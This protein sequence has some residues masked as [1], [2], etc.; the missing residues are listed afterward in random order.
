MMKDIVSKYLLILFGVIACTVSSCGC[1]GSS[2]DAE[3]PVN[4]PLV[5]DSDVAILVTSNDRTL[6]LA[7]QGAQLVSGSSMSPL[8]ITL[9]P[10]IRYQTMDGFGSAITGSACYNLMKMTLADRTKFLKY[11]FSHSEGLGQSYVRISIG[12]SDFSL[13][14]YTCCDNPGIEN[15][16]LMDEELNLVIP[17][18]KEI[19]AIN[20]EIKIIGSPWTSPRWMKVNNLTDLAPFNSW[21]SGHLNPKFYADYGTYFVKW[22]QAMA[23]HGITIYSV[24]P[25]NEPLNRGN[26]ASL[27][28]GWEEQLA[29]VKQGLGP[30]LKAAGLKTKIYLFDHNYN[31]DNMADQDNYPL[32]IYGDQ[33]VNQYVA[34]AAYHNY[35]G[36]RS[37]LLDIQQQAPD[38][39][40]IFTETSIGTWNDGRN[41]AVRL[42]DD[43]EEVAL[44]AVNNWCRGVLVWNLMLDSERGPNRVGGCQTCYGAVDINADYKS[45]VRNSHYYIIGHLSSVVKPGATRIGTRGYTEQGLVYSAFENSDGSYAFVLLNK[46]DVRKKININ[47]GSEYF[48]YEV[49]AKSVVSYRWKTKQK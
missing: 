37:E 28:M 38:K 36:A 3:E 16:G 48:V 26:S 7:R 12:C 1:D 39:E 29:F 24:T 5:D 49:P 11:S 21:T 22:I 6:D 43:M 17:I 42:M 34:G 30:K 13:S 15:F 10:A 32:K 23:S 18:L 2:S 9:D 45:M 8:T 31:Y 44:G 41:L 47:S 33:E 27:F 40:L 35:G 19:I 25:Q 20:P 14:E 46:T 4:P